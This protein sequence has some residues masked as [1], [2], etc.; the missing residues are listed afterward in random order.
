MRGGGINI[1][2][3]TAVVFDLDGTLV[4]SG[5]DI[6]AAANHAR[7][8]LGLSALDP[9]VAIAYVGDGVQRLLE[10]VLA[11]DPIAGPDA[12]IVIAAELETGLARFREHYAAHLLDSTGLYPGIG[13]LLDQLVDRRLFIATNKPR[14]FTLAILEGLRIRGRFEQVVAGDDGVARKPDP[15]HVA[16]CLAGTGITADQVTLVGDSTNDILAARAFGCQAVG[17]T[18]G[19]VPAA[20]LMAAGPDALVDDAAGLAAVLGVGG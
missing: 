4:D 6:A 20:E 2:A 16:A 15:A 12:R 3:G 11:H 19:L 14:S 5:T 13:E 17:V 9:P 10:R 18:W 8:A 1:L 7:V